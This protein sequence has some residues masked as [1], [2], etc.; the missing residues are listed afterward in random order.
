[1]I[2]SRALVHRLALGSL[3]F[4]LAACGGTGDSG[5]FGGGTGTSG[6]TT[7]G[8]GTG[9]GGSSTTGTTGTGHG[10]GG[11]G[12]ATGGAGGG[13]PGCTPGEVADCYTGPAGTEGVGACKAGKK[14]CAPD[15]AGFGA[16]EGEVLPAPETCLAPGDEDCDGQTNEEGA[17][18]VCAPGSSTPCYTGP[19]GTLGVGVC[20]SGTQACLDS[21]LGYGN[22]EGEVLPQTE[23]CDTPVD[24]DCDGLVNESG[25]GCV[26]VPGAVQSCY[27]GPAGTL[28]VGVCQAG[29]QA[30]D[31][32]GKSWGACL[33]QVLPSQENCNDAVDDDCNGLVNEGGPGCVCLP[34]STASCYEG[35][36]GTQGVGVCKGGT[37]TCNALGTGYGACQGQVVPSLDTCTNALDDDCNGSAFTC[38]ADQSCDAGSNTCV[39]DPCAP[40]VLG[41]SNVGCEYYAAVTDNRQLQDKVGFQFGVSVQNAGAAAATITITRGGVAVTSGTVAAG[42]AQFFTLPWIVELVSP[43]SSLVSR[44]AAAGGAYR[45]V[46]SVPVTVAQWSTTAATGPN[47]AYSATND[48]SLLLPV[49]AWGSSYRVASRARQAGRP[50]FYAVV[51]AQ[52]NT[53]V[54]LVP[55][56]TGKTVQPGGGV[57]ADGTGTV[58]LAKGDVLEVLTAGGN[59]DPDPS[60]LTGTL[61]SASAPVQV[62]GGHECTQVP[63]NVFACDH[64]EEVMLPLSALGKTY[65]LT[66]P[67]VE[68]NT[69]RPHVV[70]V[71]GTQPGTTLAY[72]PPIPNAPASIANAGDFVE[73][74]PLPDAFKLTASAK[75]LVADYIADDNGLVTNVDPAMTL[76]IPIEQQRTG[77]P[78]FAP[79]TGGFA[80]F[81]NV[82]APIGAQVL[83]D[84][85]PPAGPWTPIGASGLAWARVPLAAGAHA[86][87]S[88][89]PIGAQVYGLAFYT[90]VYYPAGT[91]LLTLP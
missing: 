17:G 72:E 21:G 18:C 46:S 35:P 51:A 58:T 6:A 41:T 27:S 54:T 83:V 32:L 16:C 24:D 53:V 89:Q 1:M 14:T 47:N 7:T 44:A 74:G 2:R 62:F 84:G 63:Y 30:C 34:G 87:S 25:P 82:T 64:L 49:N 23:T 22:C 56:A 40:G 60:D 50:G 3:P 59:T 36:P 15:G 81:V 12:G 79:A 91:N 55:S 90:A 48:T 67:R 26:C 78:L 37:K 43:Q 19:A 80:T 5:L 10:G 70:R 85:A 77:Y 39:K 33:G 13:S 28:G 69:A 11:G 29:T 8:T 4:V 75:V 45:I 57:A 76:A 52:D 42:T 66:S 20:K 38:P 31:A 73:I 61:V 86:V 68:A 88:A 65:V 71:V 9:A